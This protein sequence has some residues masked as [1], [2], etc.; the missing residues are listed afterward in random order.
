M[1]STQD[2]K[3]SVPAGSKHTFVI[4]IDC[5]TPAVNP[6]INILNVTRPSLAELL[7]VVAQ[8]TECN[9][10]DIV[11]TSRKQYILFTRYAY[12]LLAHCRY[13]YTSP[14]V[15]RSVN[16]DHSTILSGIKAWNNMLDTQH[17]DAIE[18]AVYVNQKLEQ[19][20]LKSLY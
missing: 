16:R 14:A 10:A 12:Y 15:G 3:L 19:L 5:A 20:K 2:I 9:V 8:A 13:N 1:D 11:G 17:D 6:T 7:E 4:T 18:V